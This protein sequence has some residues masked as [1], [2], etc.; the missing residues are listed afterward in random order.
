MLSNYAESHEH[1]FKMSECTLWVRDQLKEKEI[2]VAR[3]AI[4]RIIHWAH[5]GGVS[6]GRVDTKSSAV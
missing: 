3:K 1:E 6:L 2:P 4:Q 5:H